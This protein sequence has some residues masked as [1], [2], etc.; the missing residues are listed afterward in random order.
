MRE[1]ATQAA[2]LRADTPPT[3]TPHPRPSHL[4]CPALGG[5]CG[6][7]GRIYSAVGTT[8]SGAGSCSCLHLAGSILHQRFPKEGKGGRKEKVNAGLSLAAAS[9]FTGGSAYVRLLIVFIFTRCT[10]KR[11]GCGGGWGVESVLRYK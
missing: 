5:G 9:A 6:G 3:R 10:Q 4:S 8:P 2:G 1:G 7:V 11:K